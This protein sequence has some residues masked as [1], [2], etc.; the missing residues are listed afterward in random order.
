M[1]HPVEYPLKGGKIEEKRTKGRGGG[2]LGDLGEF[3]KHPQRTA[4]TTAGKGKVHPLES[5]AK[6]SNQKVKGSATGIGARLPREQV[7]L[8]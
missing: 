6:D 2:K 5:K 3:E 8:R 7:G 1:I 4:W